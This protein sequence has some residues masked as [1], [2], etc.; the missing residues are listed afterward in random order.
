MKVKLKIK[1]TKMMKTLIIG[2]VLTEKGKK[3]V[4]TKKVTMMMK[5]TMMMDLM[6]EK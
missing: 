1:K 5:M 4:L 2:K 3:V 6:E